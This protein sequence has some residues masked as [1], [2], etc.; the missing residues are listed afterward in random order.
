MLESGAAASPS[1]CR[2]CRP[3]L[4]IDPG[5]LTEEPALLLLLQ[6]PPV[7]RPLPLR[8]CSQ[9][10]GMALDS[11][12]GLT[13]ENPLE[14]PPL[15]S[16]EPSSGLG[17]AGPSTKVLCSEI[18]ER[19]PCCDQGRLSS[20]GFIFQP[21]PLAGIGCGRMRLAFNATTTLSKHEDLDADATAAGGACSSKN[22]D[23]MACVTAMREDVDAA[24]G[25]TPMRGRRMRWAAAGCWSDSVYCVTG[26]AERPEVLHRAAW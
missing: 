8:P 19:W 17:W 3:Q 1:L 23:A 16:P 22:T 7:E 20:N 9:A 21:P 5:S 25:D 6:A 12:H 10:R 4:L 11:S 13:M 24:G 2:L 14:P 18:C 26:G 15:L